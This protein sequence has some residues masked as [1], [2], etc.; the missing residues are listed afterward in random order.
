MASTQNPF[1]GPPEDNPY[2]VPG[3]GETRERSS[4]LYGLGAY[5]TVRTALHLIYYG[6]TALLIGSLL[7][8]I[9]L[10][11]FGAPTYGTSNE[12]RGGLFILFGL[13]VFVCSLAMIVGFVTCL[14]SPGP[15]EKSKIGIAICCQVGSVILSFA[16]G[17][18]GA[19]TEPVAGLRS[20]VG[21]QIVGTVGGQILGVMGSIFFT[22][23]CKQ[24]GFNIESYRLQDAAQSALK[25]LLIVTG[26]WVAYVVMVFAGVGHTATSSPNDASVGIGIAWLMGFALLLF[27]I[28]SL[29]KQLVMLRTGFEEL[30]V[31]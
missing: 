24:V 8:M 30:T 9:S 27:G 29:V 20:T 25:W 12:M 1:A 10:F 18:F 4:D 14:T 17:Y 31:K 16:G 3:N 19:T 5:R 21:I 2:Q 26:V 11:T 7:F 23:F 22:L 6:L 28:I 13:L 15:N